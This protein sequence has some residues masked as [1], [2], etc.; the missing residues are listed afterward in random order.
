MNRLSDAEVTDALATCPGW[1]RRGLEI[2]RTY[3]LP[4]FRAALALVA[5]AGEIAEALGHHPDIDVRYNRVT[6]AL[7]THDAGGLTANDF[8]FV[9]AL[10]G[11]G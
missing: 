8:A 6:L 3:T 11:L 9:R 4:S 2:V 1:S 5:L 10:D 7:T